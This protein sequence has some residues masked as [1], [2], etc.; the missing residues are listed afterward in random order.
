MEGRVRWV[1]GPLTAGKRVKTASVDREDG[2]LSAVL[3]MCLFMSLGVVLHLSIWIPNNIDPTTIHVIVIVYYTS[4]ILLT[5]LLMCWYMGNIGRWQRMGILRWSNHSETDDMDTFHQ[6]GVCAP[7]FRNQLKQLMNYVSL[8]CSRR[9]IHVNLNLIGVIFFGTGTILVILLHIIAKIQC[10]SDSSE[11]HFLWER[12]ILILNVIS[13]IHTVI[14]M[15]FLVKLHG[16]VLQ[17]TR[18]FQYTLFYII[19]TNVL[20]Y[21]YI[22][23]WE[24]SEGVAKDEQGTCGHTDTLE[25]M[26][27]RVEDA[28]L[29]FITEFALVSIGMLYQKWE[30]LEDT[31]VTNTSHNTDD[32]FRLYTKCCRICRHD[33]EKQELAKGGVSATSAPDNS[34]K[35]NDQTK[36]DVHSNYDASQELVRSVDFG[37]YSVIPSQD[38]CPTRYGTVNGTPRHQSQC[39]T[40]GLTAGVL[41]VLIL[42]ILSKHF[43]NHGDSALYVYCYLI[44]FDTS[45]LLCN[46]MGFK[47]VYPHVYRQISVTRVQTLFIISINGVFLWYVFKFVAAFRFDSPSGVQQA[48][49][50]ILCISYATVALQTIVQT[51][52]LLTALK[53]RPRRAVSS[54]VLNEIVTF[55]II[56]NLGLWIL[57]SFIM[58]DPNYYTDPLE[59]PV[60]NDQIWFISSNLALPLAIFYRFH[61]FAVAYEIF[62]N[63]NYSIHNNED[64]DVNDDTEHD[65]HSIHDIF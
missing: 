42:L 20:I 9:H 25:L 41:P 1:W 59:N 3:V 35:T 48:L 16:A 12:M 61:A 13:L 63:F 27:T 38:Y 14:Q 52:F 19:A 4:S 31:C 54:R 21:L 26:I 11:K 34:N 51:S 56:A 7:N 62:A 8:V 29:P 28:I 17:N 5:I 33:N 60:Y 65:R 32:S 18:W 6:Q 23:V 46:W 30:T 44:I 64:N 24:I 50:A 22:Y 2:S 55:I 58:S 43:L 40:I 15:C 53:Y 39:Y 37:D 36:D 10:L 47:L 49:S 57:D 45:L